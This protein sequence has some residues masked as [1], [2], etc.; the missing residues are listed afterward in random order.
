MGRPRGWASERTPT[1]AD[2]PAS[3]AASTLDSPRAIAA[4]NRTRCSLRLAGGRPGERIT[5]RPVRS[6]VCSRSCGCGSPN[7]T[8]LES[9]KVLS[10]SVCGRH[11]P[12]ED[13]L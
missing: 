8:G 11:D 5:G 9:W 4:Q 13:R 6:V 2:T 7:L 1:T 3:A 10:S 12:G